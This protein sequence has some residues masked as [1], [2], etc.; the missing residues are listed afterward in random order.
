MT[1]RRQARQRPPQRHAE[2]HAS[3]TTLSAQCMGGCAVIAGLL[4]RSGVLCGNKYGTARASRPDPPPLYHPNT[5]HT[6]NAVDCTRG[7]SRK[8]REARAR[9]GGECTALEATVQRTNPRCRQAPSHSPPPCSPPAN[10]GFGMAASSRFLGSVAPL[11]LP[12][13]VDDDSIRRRPPRTDR[14]CLGDTY[15]PMSF[16]RPATRGSTRDD[17]SS[18]VESV[19]RGGGVAALSKTMSHVSI[20]SRVSSLTPDKAERL[21]A[22]QQRFVSCH[23]SMDACGVACVPPPLWR[24]SCPW[25][26]CSL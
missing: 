1:S 19:T 25:P 8:T 7:H 23:T 11:P 24:L 12:R 10:D 3:P 4:Q 9:A 5:P 16:A 20:G 14:A 17:R 13:A 21:R 2:H 22:I 26:L 18:V 15:Y 6:Q